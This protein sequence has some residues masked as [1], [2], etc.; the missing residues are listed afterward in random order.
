MIKVSYLGFVGSGPIV[1]G[2][3]SVA[4]ISIIP[5]T[6]WSRRKAHSVL[7]LSRLNQFPLLQDGVHSV[8]I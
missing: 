3:Y 2:P 7:D 8:S 6:S 5:M 4:S 1:K